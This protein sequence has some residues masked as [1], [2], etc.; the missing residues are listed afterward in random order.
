MKLFEGIRRTF[1]WLRTPLLF[2][3]A[4]TVSVSFFAFVFYWSIALIVSFRF[5]P[6]T[7][8]QSGMIVAP[9]AA[10]GS[11]MVIFA[12]LLGILGGRLKLPTREWLAKTCG[13]LA[14]C[15][16]IGEVITISSF[17]GGYFFDRY[18]TMLVAAIV[19]AIVYASLRFYVGSLRPPSSWEPFFSAAS[20]LGFLILSAVSIAWVAH[21]NSEGMALLTHTDLTAYLPWFD[22]N[23]ALPVI[24]GRW[25]LVGVLAFLFSSRTGNNH[26]SMHDFYRVRLVRCY[27]RPS[28]KG[29]SHKRRDME[30]HEDDDVALCAFRPEGREASYSGP[31]PIFNCALNT[32]AGDELFWQ[33]RKACSFIFTPLHCGFEPKFSETGTFFNQGAYADTDSFD[34]ANGGISLGRAMAISGAALSPHMGDRSSRTLA[35]LLTILNLRLGWWV[36]NPWRTDNSVPA[37]RN[38]LITLC[39]ELF[40]VT[41]ERAEAVYLSD[42]GHFEGLGIYELIHRRCRLI[43]AIDA[44]ADPELMS[45][46]LGNVLEKCR[47]DFGVEIDSLKRLAEGEHPVGLLGKIRYR[48]EGGDTEGVLVLVKAS[49]TGREPIDLRTYHAAHKEFPHEATRHQWFSEKQF[50]SYRLLGERNMSYVIDLLHGTTPLSTATASN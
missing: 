41:S 8:R 44:S 43:I 14:L 47:V 1:N 46:A 45:S 6:L 7:S 26:L 18:L 19:V 36:P 30:L 5:I 28:I 32:L 40:G 10:L 11:L 50:E 33:E 20:R 12:S 35:F 34:R 13:R 22:S 24:Y 49:T 27:L 2:V 17:T 25:M 3:C 39:R 21:I 15:T 16:V 31:F 9:L 23:V 38:R 37:I 29:P 4:I 48:D 42:G